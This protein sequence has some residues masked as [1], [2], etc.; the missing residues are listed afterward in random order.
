M[1]P[2]I[3]TLID[4]QDNNEIVRDQVAAILA[5]E[6][7]NQVALATTAGKPDPE[8]WDFDVTIERSRPWQLLSDPD[9]TEQGDL[10]KG[11]VNVYFESDSFDNPG[12]DL[13]KN[14]NVKGNITIDCYGFKNTSKNGAV[15][16]FGDELSSYEVDRVSRLVRNILMA[17]E[18]TYLGFARGQIV[19]KRFIIRREKFKLDQTVTG[20]ENV[21]G[22]RLTL[23]VDY[24]EFSPQAE[25][26][27]LD[28]LITDCERS[29]TGQIYFK[30][31][32]T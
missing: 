21:V 4:K 7:A 11:L 13:I 2:K 14:Q 32:A 22:E 23:R 27:T 29:D 18:Y 8:D 15:V 12:S 28:L 9:G 30:Y 25:L 26:E 5:I 1:P 20:A 6:K 19:Q 10:K 24:I 31:Q 3:T 16:T 17:G